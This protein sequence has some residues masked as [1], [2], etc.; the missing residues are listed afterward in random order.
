MAMVISRTGIAA[1][2]PATRPSKQ[3]SESD[4]ALIARIAKR[5][6]AAMRAL[7]ARHQ[8]AVYRWLRRIVHDEALAE[9]LLSE[10]FLDLWR[11][12]AS[13]FAGRSSVSTWLLGIAR[14]KAL[15]ACRRRQDEQL[16]GE[17]AERICDPADDPETVL[18]A[19][20]RAERL[21]H[22]LRNLSQ[23]HRAVID[24]VYYHGKSVNEVAALLGV[25]PGTVKT[26]MF[27]ARR[28]LAASVDAGAALAC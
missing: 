3:I 9:D 12:A 6:H 4:S 24:L 5:D 23:A 16:D 19:R 8:V 15:S 22:A 2:S 14:H 1:Q 17:L 11:Q 21:V 13:S 27:H 10:V 7:F 20:N 26:R 18:D 25:P 28:K